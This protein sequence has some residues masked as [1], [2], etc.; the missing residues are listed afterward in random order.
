MHMFE[1]VIMRSYAMVYAIV[2]CL[3]VTPSILS[4][5]LNLGPLS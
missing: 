3:S 5:L 2:V 4:K 1:I